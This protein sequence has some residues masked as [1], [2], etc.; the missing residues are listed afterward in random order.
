MGKIIYRR[1]PFWYEDCHSRYG[2]SHCRDSAVMRP[3]YLYTGNVYTG[4]MESFYYIDHCIS[5]E[6]LIYDV[7]DTLLMFYTD[8]CISLE[9]LIYDVWDTLL[10]FYTDHC[11]SLEVLIYDVWD[12][13][14]MFYTDHCISLEVLI[15]DVWDTLLM[16]YTVG[17]NFYA[18]QYNMIIRM[19]W[20]WTHN[21]YPYHLLQ[22]EPRY[23]KITLT[24]TLRVSAVCC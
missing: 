21:I 12:T 24:V 8:H 22:V 11:I 1:D 6:V 16:F 19:A 2:D 4:K 18:C 5:L 20:Q 7:W 9:V 15:Y 23:S 3:S 13:L 10:M 17:S 14:L